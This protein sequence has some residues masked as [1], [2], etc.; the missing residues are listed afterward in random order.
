MEV[1]VIRPGPPCFFLGVNACSNSGITNC[2]ST[3][4]AYHKEDYVKLKFDAVE[5]SRKDLDFEVPLLLKVSM[6]G[7]DECSYCGDTWRSPTFYSG[8]FGGGVYRS[9]FYNW[10]ISY[11]TKA[12]DGGPTQ[13]VKECVFE[14]DRA[15]LAH[16]LYGVYMWLVSVYEDAIDRG[17]EPLVFRIETTEAFRQELLRRLPE[18]EGK[19]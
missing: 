6:S 11:R 1:P 3:L 13:S 12:E 5:T 9:L 17:D 7:L 8:L 4:T 16:R 2:V 15:A 18:L 10:D 14:K 19:L